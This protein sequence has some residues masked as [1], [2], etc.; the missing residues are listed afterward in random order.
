MR[1]QPASPA[2]TQPGRG[3]APPRHDRHRP[4]R[5]LLPARPSRPRAAP[6]FRL[7]RG[8]MR[9]TGSSAGTGRFRSAPSTVRA[10]SRRSRLRPR[11]PCH[12]PPPGHVPRQGTAWLRSRF[13]SRRRLSRFRSRRRLSRSRPRWPRSPKPPLHPMPPGV[14]AAAQ[15][16]APG[17]PRRRGERARPP[18]RGQRDRVRDWPAWSGGPSHRTGLRRGRTK[19]RQHLPQPLGPGPLRSNRRSPSTTRPRPWR[20]R[21]RPGAVVRP[22]PVRTRHPGRRRPLPATPRASSGPVAARRVAP[23][24]GPLVPAPESLAASPSRARDAFDLPL[25][26]PSTDPPAVPLPVGCQVLAHL[27]R[28]P[29]V[30]HTR[31]LGRE[32]LVHLA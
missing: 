20:T 4:R 13:R 1:R 5:C 19:A 22:A 24:V 30:L 23:S 10:P 28:R 8:R 2:W 17:R 3:P 6:R 27:H 25:P 15:E 18:P 14:P 29:G 11:T 7:W 32:R 9:S 26:P 16:P 21:C 31:G 12:Q